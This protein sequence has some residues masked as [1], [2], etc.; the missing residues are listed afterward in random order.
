MKNM[1]VSVSFKPGA[2]F[3]SVRVARFSTWNWYSR[4]A[5]VLEHYVGDAIVA[6][7]ARA[8]WSC[9]SVPIF[10]RFCLI[11]SFFFSVVER[12]S[13][14]REQFLFGQTTRIDHARSARIPSI[15]C[16]SSSPSCVPLAWTISGASSWPHHLLSRWCSHTKKSWSTFTFIS[17]YSLKCTIWC[18]CC[19]TWFRSESSLQQDD[20]DEKPIKVL[21]FHCTADRSAE[22]LLPYLQVVSYR[23]C[24][25]L[26]GL[27]RGSP[28]PTFDLLSAVQLSFT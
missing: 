12:H 11:V 14:D 6:C 13:A 8:H 15:E 1:F 20:T 3:W 19:A 23:R 26:L 25:F 4:S 10:R 27:Y 24:W 5:S 2:R 28:T 21:L 18:Q 7:L 16:L 17:Q 9:R 22:S